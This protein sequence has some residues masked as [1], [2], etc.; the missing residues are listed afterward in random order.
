MKERRRGTNVLG[1][2]Y[3]VETEEI[4]RGNLCPRSQNVS[5][6]HLF[7][8]L[9]LSLTPRAFH[10]RRSSSPPS[11]CDPCACGMALRVNAG[12][13]TVSFATIPNQSPVLPRDFIISTRRDGA[14]MLI[15]SHDEDAS[16]SRCPHPASPLCPLRASPHRYFRTGC[17][18][19][20]SD[21]HT[22]WSH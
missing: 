16:N 22:R 5:P 12:T 6:Q 11:L 14:L 1:G 18:R 21:H 10:T 4:R 2:E 3:V 15:P 13:S 8:L 17:M 19:Q 7:N 9:V 20:P